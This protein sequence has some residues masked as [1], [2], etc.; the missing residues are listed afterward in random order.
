MQWSYFT[1]TERVF[2]PDQ[3]VAV[4]GARCKMSLTSLFY[5]F[6][7][8]PSKQNISSLFSGEDAEP[9][10]TVSGREHQCSV[11]LLY[12]CVC[13]KKYFFPKLVSVY[14]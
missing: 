8:S 11:V 2:S 13:L 6:I 7:Y 1:L 3:S 4:C 9:F 14:C 10:T 12:F 5:L